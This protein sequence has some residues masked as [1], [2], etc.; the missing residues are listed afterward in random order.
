[1]E[2]TKSNR[3]RKRVYK[4]LIKTNIYIEQ[5]TLDRLNQ[6]VDLTNELNGTDGTMLSNVIRSILTKNSLVLLS[7][8]NK[9][10]S[11]QK[12]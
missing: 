9:K 12:K 3:G 5:E 1:M 10:T 6:I 2:T 8:L 11:K 4:D 7:D